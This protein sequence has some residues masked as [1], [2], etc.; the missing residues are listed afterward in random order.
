MAGAAINFGS[1]N[2]QQQQSN[3]AMNNTPSQGKSGG[4]ARQV[5]SFGSISAQPARTGTPAGTKSNMNGKPNSSGAS[6]NGTS[7][8]SSSSAQTTLDVK[9][10]FRGGGTPAPQSA[11]SISTSSTAS[12]ASSASSITARSFARCTH[13]FPPR[14]VCCSV[15]LFCGA[16]T[17]HTYKYFVHS[18]HLPL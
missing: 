2:D 14:F 11:S 12:F 15:D 3:A 4:E 1:V 17:W 9:A 5:Q 10:L 18:V 6:T 7:T 16:R 13:G 8:P